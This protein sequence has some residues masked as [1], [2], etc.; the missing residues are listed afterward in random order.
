VDNPTIE[1]LT[2]GLHLTFNPLSLTSSDI[3][4]VDLDVRTVSINGTAS[5]R[6]SLTSDSQWW[7][8]APGTATIRYRANTTQV[9]SQLAL[10]FASAWL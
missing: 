8:I 6:A 3:L 10:S 2:S 9:G 7:E 5:R 4:T 1:N